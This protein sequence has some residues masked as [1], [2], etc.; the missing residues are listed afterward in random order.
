MDGQEEEALNGADENLLKLLTFKV[1]KRRWIVLLA[2]CLLNCSNALL[3]LSFAP[4]ADQ[5][6][7][8][9]NVTLDQVN[10]LS[11]VYLIVAIP[12][13]FGTSW[14]LDT[15]GLKTCLILSSWLNMIGS[16]LRYLSTVNTNIYPVL[17]VGQTISALAQ[18]LV[19]FSPTKLAALWFPEH[20][21]A[22]A[23]MLASMSNPL[24][25]LLANILSPII[26]KEVSDIP[27]LLVI[28]AI[29]AS[30]ACVLATGGIR[31]TV[32]PTP[33]SA[34]AMMSTSENFIDGVKLLIKNKPYMILLVCFGAGIGIFTCFSTLLE[35]ILC[36]KGY[37][38]GFAGL[39]GALFIVFGILGAFLLGI[40]VDKTKYFTEVTKISFCLTAIASIAFAVLSQMMNQKPALAVICSL[41][42][43]FG[44]AIY[45]I[46]LELAVECS[47]P[48]GE[49]TSAGLIFISGQIQG[50]IF[51]VLFQ[52]MT[53]HLADSPYSTC[54]LQDDATLS[55]KVPTLVMAA[56]CTVGACFFVL[57]FHTEYKRLQKETLISTGHD[58]EGSEETSNEEQRAL[59]ET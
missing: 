3:W 9:Y 32:P 36:V 13:G 35:Q 40:Y 25:V 8:F 24:G 11:L 57:F 58:S 21:R 23:N 14:M 53:K 52:L 51:I 31:E 59:Q 33:P 55:W 45:P 12:F 18:P 5:T 20:Q 10:L 54:K 38:N 2:L 37:S 1:Y 28:Y 42:G 48:V 46:S 4:I 29:P 47:Y 41:F 50:V 6:S 15:V 26:V 30:V 22:T 34:T 7:R 39:C 44:F 27:T 16:I 56:I 19:L 17:M 49:A 43:M